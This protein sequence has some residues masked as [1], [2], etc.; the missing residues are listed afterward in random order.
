MDWDKSSLIGEGKGEEKP[1]MQM[2]L[3][4]SSHKHSGALT[5]W[6]VATLEDTSSSAPVFTAE[7]DIIWC[8]MSLWVIQ[9]NCPS[10]FPSQFLFILSLVVAEGARAEWEKEKAFKLCMHCSAVAKN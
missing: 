2:Q 8:A 6:A 1:S 9:V 3:R 10:G 4:T 7:R 5:V